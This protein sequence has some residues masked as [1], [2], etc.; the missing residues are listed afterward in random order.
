MHWAAIAH[1]E[2]DLVDRLPRHKKFDRL[3]QPRLSAPCLE[4]RANFAMETP[5]Y[6][7]DVGACLGA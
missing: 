6:R 7:A 4:I 2:S 5:L 1:G 3:H